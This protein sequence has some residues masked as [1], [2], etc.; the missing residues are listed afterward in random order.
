MPRPGQARG[1]GSGRTWVSRAP[2]VGQML[3]VGLLGGCGGKAG[4][5]D[6]TNVER[7]ERIERSFG[8]TGLSPGQFAYPRCMDSDGRDL[9]VIDKVA[10]VQRIDGQT[11]A[12][13]VSWRMPEWEKGKPTGVTVWTPAG[14]DE[15][16]YVFV[17]DTHYHRVMVYRVGA[18]TGDR[19]REP[20]LVTRFGEYGE[21]P[22]QFI[23]PTDIAVEPTEDGRGV[24]RLWVSEYGGND[25]I[26]VFVPADAATV[27]DAE[28]SDR[29]AALP[30]AWRCER[31]L[32][33]RSDG[34]PN[35]EVLSFS[36]PQSLALDLSRKRLVIA[37]ACNHR[38]IVADLEGAVERTIGSMG[39][40]GEEPGRFS[41]PYGLELLDDGS[42]LVS[43]FGNCRVQR[44]DPGTGACLGVY[45][46]RGRGLKFLAMPWAVASIGGEAYVLDS[47]H[48]RVAVYELPQGVRAADDR[49]GRGAI[50]SGGA[51]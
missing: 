6:A 16:E 45:G 10:R 1:T 27:G 8:E 15:D 18:P 25:R 17:A 50:A 4:P 43:E 24:A 49:F 13:V 31:T 37:D 21:G 47:G 3:V 48:D 5:Y 29:Q 9:W 26:S 39:E 28:A 23:Y 30:T 7:H 42:V 19:G 34:E 41:Y 11:G 14:Q 38:L 44:I 22:G 2:I 36:R 46:G 33:G 51:H 12:S 20:E 40:V 35:A 32:G